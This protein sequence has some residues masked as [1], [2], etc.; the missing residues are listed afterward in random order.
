MQG[1]FSVTFD[2]EDFHWLVM[3]PHGKIAH[4]FPESMFVDAERMAIS[5]NWIA[6]REWTNGTER[7]EMDNSDALYE[8]LSQKVTENTANLFRETHEYFGKVD[9]NLV[10]FT[11]VMQS[12]VSSLVVMGMIYNNPVSEETYKEFTDFVGKELGEG[13][14]NCLK[15]LEEIVTKPRIITE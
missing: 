5:L 4:R 3:T 7:N 14:G 10:V 15:R 8:F 12:M 1:R 6:F 13:L 9:V 2:K 11:Q